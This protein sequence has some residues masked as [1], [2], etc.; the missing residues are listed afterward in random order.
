MAVN[1]NSSDGKR[2][3]PAG[4]V[5]AFPL[6]PKSPFPRRSA[7]ISAL[8]ITMTRFNESV[9]ASNANRWTSRRYRLSAG[10]L[11]YRRISMSC[12]SAAETTSVATARMSPNTSASWDVSC[13]AVA[14]VHGYANFGQGSAT[15]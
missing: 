6:M 8:A 4:S 12:N 1:G 11:G 3:Y 2:L 13:T 9:F 14:H 5:S 15:R 10:N 7:H